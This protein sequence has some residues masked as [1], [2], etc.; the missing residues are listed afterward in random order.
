MI[1][2][3][4]PF[5]SFSFLSTSIDPLLSLHLSRHPESTEGLTEVEREEEK[6][7]EVSTEVERD[8][9]EEEST[10]ALVSTVERSR[11]RCRRRG[12]GRRRSQRCVLSYTHRVPRLASLCLSQLEGAYFRW[13]CSRIRPGSLQESGSDRDAAKGNTGQGVPVLH[14]VSWES[15]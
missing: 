3:Q 4:S 11:L 1:A 6:S 8:S 12:R 7:T 15:L 14:V 2:G 10:E 9:E 5:D 13:A